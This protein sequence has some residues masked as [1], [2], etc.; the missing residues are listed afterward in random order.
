ML[1]E[2]HRDRINT[3][4]WHYVLNMS[5][6]YERDEPFYMRYLYCDLCD[7]FMSINKGYHYINKHTFTQC[8]PV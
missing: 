1:Q 7:T 3:I 4:A 6:S 8:I 5:K 2:L